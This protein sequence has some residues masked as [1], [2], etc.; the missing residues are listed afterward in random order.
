MSTQQKVQEE[1]TALAHH[2]YVR[3]NAVLE[4]WR[5]RVDQDAD[6]TSGSGLS[7]T[8]FNDHIPDILDAFARRLRAWPEE[9]GAQV[10]GLEIK[11]VAAHGLHRWQQGFR[12]RE[13]TR[14]WG[15]LQ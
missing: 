12:L 15:Y 8:A 2:L 3:R 6:L 14:E 10:R 9:I 1:L 5:A 13:L 4:A 7:R 11:G